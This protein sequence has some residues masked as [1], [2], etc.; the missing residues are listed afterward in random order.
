MTKEI[1]LWEV[2]WPLRPRYDKLKLKGIVWAN[3]FSPGAIFRQNIRITDTH[4]LFTDFLLPDKTSLSASKS[5]FHYAYFLAWLL[6]RTR[7]M[8]LQIFCFPIK[9]V[10]PPQR[11]HFTMPTSWHDYYL[12]TCP[13]S[14]KRYSF[15][16]IHKSLGRDEIFLTPQKFNFQPCLTDWIPNPYPL[17]ENYIPPSLTSKI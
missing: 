5:A 4:N 14:Q 6:S 16:L 3:T 2:Y 1:I 8:Y 10:F 13:S 12:T 7:I 9:R 15:H 17:A 11:A